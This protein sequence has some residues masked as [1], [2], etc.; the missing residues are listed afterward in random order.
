MHTKPFIF[1][2]TNFCQSFLH[3]PGHYIEQWVRWEGKLSVAHCDLF[4]CFYTFPLHLNLYSF[5]V[6]LLS[7]V[8]KLSLN[9][10]RRPIKLLIRRQ[11]PVVSSLIDRTRLARSTTGPASS[12]KFRP[13]FPSRRRPLAG[14]DRSVGG[15]LVLSWVRRRHDARVSHSTT[16][17]RTV[18]VWTASP[19]SRR[20]RHGRVSL[21]EAR[22]LLHRQLPPPW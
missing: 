19:A 17:W 16:G 21:L 18:T 6:F 4:A 12:D 13:L 3:W 14:T 1:I 15:G 20:D 11:S 9:L 10:R 5:I 8:P 2:V 7:L 22:L